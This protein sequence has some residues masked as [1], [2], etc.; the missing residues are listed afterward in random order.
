M[1][2]VMNKK[3]PTTFILDSLLERPEEWEFHKDP[4]YCFITHKKSEFCLAF[5]HEVKVW[6]PDWAKLHTFSAEDRQ[7]IKKAILSLQK[8]RNDIV[9]QTAGNKIAAMFEP[10][11]LAT[12]TQSLAPL[13][14]GAAFFAIS[15]ILYAVYFLVSRLG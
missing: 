11:K 8:E 6:S 5:H 1:K 7:M 15:V 4:T 13:G 9:R 14:F 3:D 10:P 12:V 2:D